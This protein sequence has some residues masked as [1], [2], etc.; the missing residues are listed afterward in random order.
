MTSY[1]VEEC[2]ATPGFPLS[3]VV[4][5]DRLRV[6][7]VLEDARH[8]V[9]AGDVSFRLRRRDGRVVWMSM[10]LQPVQARDGA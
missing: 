1:S 8:G 10:F 4:A 7:A 2:L 3:W 9:S 6:A 5:D